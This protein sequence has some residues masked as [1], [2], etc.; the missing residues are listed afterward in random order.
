MIFR[1]GGSVQLIEPELVSVK[2]LSRMIDVSERTI[3]DWVYRSRKEH[4]SDP[5]P[6]HKIGVLVRFNVKEIRSWYARRRVAP[7]MLVRANFH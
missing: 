3:S 5:I 7:D 2:T 1:P 6:Y 4:L